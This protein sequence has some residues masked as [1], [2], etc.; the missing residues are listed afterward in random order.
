MLGRAGQ[1]LIL[2][3]GVA[4][5]GETS[6]I[7][8]AIA[9][10]RGPN[11][12]AEWHGGRALVAAGDAA[13]PALE[14][15]AGPP[16]PL[17]PRLIAVELLGEIG[18]KAAMDALTGILKGEKVLAVRGQICMQLG[19]ARE[20]RA[21]P[22]LCEWLKTI[23]PRALNDRGAPKESEPSTCYARHLEALGVIGDERAIPAI[24]EFLKGIPKGV[25]YGGF[26]SN[27]VLQ[28]AQ[29]AIQ[30]IKNASSDSRGNHEGGER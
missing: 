23:G 14:K 28:A 7:S 19:K 17:A 12:L 13:V 10:V 3:M 1:V 21:V 8:G 5:G 11:A 18:S 20:K 4:S 27:F 22:V 26:I 25:G 15:L 6:D 9:A 16:G 30:D 24:E 29:E 2:F